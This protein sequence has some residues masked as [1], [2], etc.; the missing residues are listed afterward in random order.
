M[1]KMDTEDLKQYLEENPDQSAYGL[2]CDAD[3]HIRKRFNR[4][5]RTLKEL[6]TDVQ[7]HFPDA[8]YYTA[9]GGLNIVLGNTHSGAHECEANRDL[10]AISAGNG[11]V[12]G[13][14]DW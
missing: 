8:N 9:S 4:V 6:I 2:L 13:D 10:S 14:G 7:K 5:C 3:P 1:R 12:I 11:I